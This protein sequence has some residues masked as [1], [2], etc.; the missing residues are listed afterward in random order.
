MPPQKNA[1]SKGAKRETN[2]SAKNRRFFQA[3]LEDLRTEGSVENVHIG[4]VLRRLGDG[5]MEVFY[6]Q[7]IKGNDS[8]GV[9]AQ[10]VIRGT[11]RGRGKWS[12]WIDVGSF[13]AVAETGVAGSSALEIVA[14]FSPEQIH[15]LK[16]EIEVDPRVLAVDLVDSSQLVSSKMTQNADAGY[17]FDTLKEDEDVDI[18]GV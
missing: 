12:V 5:R 17:M 10:A 14:V 18:D 7:A 8:K 15:D 13:V 9:V 1:G 11:F 3:L 16:A 6:T 4:R 2:A